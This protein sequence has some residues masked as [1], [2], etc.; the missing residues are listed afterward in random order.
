MC[1]L[2]ICV[3]TN[4]LDYLLYNICKYIISNYNEYIIIL[5]YKTFIFGI[6]AIAT[7]LFCLGSIHFRVRCIGIVF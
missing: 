1:R 4:G 2:N 6:V 5:S 3:D 7:F